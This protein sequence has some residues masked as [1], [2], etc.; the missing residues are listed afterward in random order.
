M[1][2]R[3]FAFV[4]V[5]IGKIIALLLWFAFGALQHTTHRSIIA[6][7][8]VSLKH[9]LSSSFDPDLRLAHTEL[10]HN[11]N[12]LKITALLFAI[13]TTKQFLI[14]SCL[15]WLP[16]TLH[17]SLVIFVKFITTKLPFLASKFRLLFSKPR[18]TKTR[19]FIYHKMNAA[20]RK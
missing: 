19:V 16:G 5:S 15:R 7:K 2:R 11:Y 14:K 9:F 1:E 18:A 10:L 6:A 12:I 17:R 4:L 13:Q 3:L 8:I 20:S